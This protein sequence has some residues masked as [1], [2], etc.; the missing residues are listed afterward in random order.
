MGGLLVMRAKSIQWCPTLCDLKDCGCQAPLSMIFFRQESW[1]GLP[2]PPPGDP[3][4]SGTQPASLLTPALADGFFTLAPPQTLAPR[5]FSD[6]SAESCLQIEGGIKNTFSTLTQYFST[7][8]FT[9]FPSPLVSKSIEQK[10]FCLA[11]P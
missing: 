7:S 11:L 6:T 1:S 4:D 9:H 2:Y 5:T 10:P 3:T 8:N